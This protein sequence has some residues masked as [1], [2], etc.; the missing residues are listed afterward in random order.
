MQDVRLYILMRTDVPTMNPGKAV[1]QGSH[2]ANQCIHEARHAAGLDDLIENS[3]ESM[4]R[5]QRAR[6]LA[7]KVRTWEEQSGDGFGTCIV[8]GVNEETMR[9]RVSRAKRAGIHA[10]ITHDPSYPLGMPPKRDLAL[11]M[12]LSAVAAIILL[13][14][15]EMW[16]ALGIASLFTFVWI[17]DLVGKVRRDR[18]PKVIPLDTCAFVFGTA[19]ECREFVG[20]L[21]LM[22]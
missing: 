21:N 20:D 13:A 14:V 6:D 4:D 5:W 15:G 11:D 17:A 1:A 10:G 8:L 2:A 18:A 16:A 19:D 12:M 22:R 9:E 3:P 7:E